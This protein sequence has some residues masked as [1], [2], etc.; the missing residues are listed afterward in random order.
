MISNCAADINAMKDAERGGQMM[1]LS[2][3]SNFTSER[4]MKALEQTGYD[5]L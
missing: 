2:D 1:V 4:Y 5:I 3:W